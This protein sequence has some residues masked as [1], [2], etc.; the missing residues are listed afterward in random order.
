MKVKDNR[1]NNSEQE[2]FNKKAADYLVDR[3]CPEGVLAK[4]DRY[5]IHVVKVKGCDEPNRVEIE[6]Y[7]KGRLM[8]Y[9]TSSV[10]S[11][12][13]GN[14]IN[15]NH[16]RSAFKSK[17]HLTEIFRCLEQEV[18]SNPDVVETECREEITLRKIAEHIDGM[19]E[20][21]KEQCNIDT[22]N[23]EIVMTIDVFEGLLSLVQKK[24]PSAYRVDMSS[25]IRRGGDLGLLYMSQGKDSRIIDGYYVGT[26]VHLCSVNGFKNGNTGEKI[27]K[28]YSHREK[29]RS[30]RTVVFK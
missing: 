8:Y 23:E 3:S 25:I 15:S 7:D 30:I 14:I 11:A 5:E 10:I 16:A 18:K 6:I 21:H 17:S 2:G 12:I 13:N 20:L 29:V 4:N 1:C 26:D 24:M 19:S 22:S 9:E 28:E 27:Y